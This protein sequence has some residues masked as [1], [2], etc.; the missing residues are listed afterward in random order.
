MS[1]RA[2]NED[3]PKESNPKDDSTREKNERLG[4]ALSACDEE[5]KKRGLPTLLQAL[6]PIIAAFETAFETD[7]CGEEVLDPFNAQ[8]MQDIV[9]MAKNDNDKYREIVA[10]TFHDD[11]WNIET[12][13][14]NRMQAT[15]SLVAVA[16]A[17]EPLC[18]PFVSP[19]V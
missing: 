16:E 1:K 5:L 6:G 3:T 8:C 18:G 15:M 2:L 4:A 13:T 11:E 9:N 10:T 17:L 19:Q 7:G 14:L 12:S